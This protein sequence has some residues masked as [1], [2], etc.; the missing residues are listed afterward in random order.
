MPHER[1]TYSVREMVYL[2][3]TATT[4]N[5][6]KIIHDVLVEDK[7][8]YTGICRRYLFE[9]FSDRMKNIVR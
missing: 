3:S 5:E 4:H 2:I 6:M 9:L 8:Q 7:N 1:P